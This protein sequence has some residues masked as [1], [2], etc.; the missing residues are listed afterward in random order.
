MKWI[1]ITGNIFSEG[2]QVAKKYQLD[3]V[4]VRY[5][6]QFHLTLCF[7]N[8]LWYLPFDYNLVIDS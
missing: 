1:G 8:K 2:W 3:S 4:F 7:I 5:Y 6:F